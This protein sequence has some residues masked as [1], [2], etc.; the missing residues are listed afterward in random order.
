MKEWSI[1]S[2]SYNTWKDNGSEAC[3]RSNSSGTL[4]PRWKDLV[5]MLLLEAACSLLAHLHQAP[6]ILAPSLS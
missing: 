5:Q 3:P 1:F 4:Q 2:P 6:G